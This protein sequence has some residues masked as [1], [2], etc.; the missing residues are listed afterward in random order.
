[1]ISCGVTQAAY[2]W[3]LSS[4]FF[5]IYQQLEFKPTKDVLCQP[6]RLDANFPVATVGHIWQHW[7]SMTG[8]STSFWPP[9]T[10]CIQRRMGDSVI[11]E[12]SV[13]VPS[14]TVEWPYV[15]ILWQK[16]VAPCS[17]LVQKSPDFDVDEFS[18]SLADG[19]AALHFFQLREFWLK[20]FDQRGFDPRSPALVW[21]SW[22]SGTGE[23]RVSSILVSITSFRLVSSRCST[24]EF[25]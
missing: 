22:A 25:R 19:M 8:V 16:C 10:R 23:P 21:T 3:I 13:T 6:K 20:V 15:L 7:T 11:Y 17:C 4:D 5:S 18:T 9:T 24:L 2:R 12:R 1:M 14:K